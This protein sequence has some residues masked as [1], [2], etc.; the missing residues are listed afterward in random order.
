MT[1]LGQDVRYAFRTLRQSKMFTAV[2]VLSLALGIGANTAIFT[3]VDSILLRWLPVSNPQELAILGLNPANPRHSFN[4]PDYRFVRDHATSY[5]G[6]IAFSGGGRP[7]SLRLAAPD[8]SSQ[9]VSL[10][11]VSGN[12]FEVLGVRP[13]LGRLFNAADNEKEGAHP[14]AVL[15]HGFWQRA[16][17]GDTAIVGRDV[18]LN[19]ARF[20]VIGVSGDGFTGTNVG[21][22]PDV[23]APIVMLKSFSPTSNFWNT[24][25]MW[26]LTMIGRLKPGVARETAQA[27]FQAL[28]QRVL[29][30]DPDKRPPQAWDREYK[31]N[32][33]A[34]VVEGSRGYSG[35]R[36]D[37]GKP[38]TILMITTGLVLLIACANIANLLLARGVGR[39]KELAVRLAIGAGRGRL[40]VQMLTEAVVISVLGGLAGL[41]IAWFGVQ[42]LVDFMPRQAFPVELNLRPDAR[43]LGF[44]F[45]LSLLTG[46]LFGL[47]P[48]LRASRPDIVSALKASSGGN[49]AGRGARWDLRRSLVSFQVAL[50]LLLLAGAGL[51]VRTLANLKGLEPGMARENVM[52][53]STTVNSLGLEPQAEREFNDRLRDEIQKLPGVRAASF[54]SIVPL[55]GSRWNGDVQIE[56]YTWRPDER[57]YLDMNAVGPRYFESTGIPV[58][59]GREFRESD[60]VPV[61]PPR[62][63]EILPRGV[64]P[65]DIP[66][67]PRVVI[68]NK[69]FADRFFK[70]QS[71]LGKRLVL[72]DKWKPEKAAEIVGV[73]ANA[74]YFDLRKPVEAMIYQ[75]AYRDGGN[76]ANHTVRT[77]GDPQLLTSAIRQKVREINPAVALTEARTI[78]EH[79]NRAVVG[80]RVVATLGTFFGVLALLLAAIGLYGVMTQT[81][82]RRSREIGIRMA[83]GAQAGRVLRMVLRDACLMVAVGGVIGIPAFLATTRFAESLLFGVT[84]QDPVTL[85]LAVVALLGVTLLA[86]FLPARR[87]TKVDPLTA[88]REE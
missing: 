16:F 84:P 62:R 26:W 24:R 87:A 35:L 46:L 66:G 41:L 47:A 88:L 86:G 59:L 4:Y 55:G 76:W 75:P 49:S 54:A 50:S 30:D 2:A 39:S 48:A 22:S 21:T 78:E 56:G 23:F 10:S 37:A 6:L 63:T 44:A 51:F 3:L 79:V 32:N 69:A 73:V 17:G 80:E 81:V 40:I 7:V 5:T 9:L 13:A 33:T 29:D 64:E 11:L 61:L 70:G 1:N 77:T 83:L 71:A 68:V 58:L 65:P 27:E 53:V 36:R 15:S 67:P 85:V 57:P 38:L 60:S 45:G 34:V 19:G 72:G 43:V 20:Q 25:R 52:F 14:Y 82:N 31:L 28:W 74:R 8:A 18:L 42:V 12:Y